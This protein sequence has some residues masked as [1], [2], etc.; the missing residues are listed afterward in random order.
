MVIVGAGLTTESPFPHRDRPAPAWSARARGAIR[1]CVKTFDRGRLA[2][3]TTSP[4]D[5]EA[6]DWLL[7]VELCP[8]L[9]LRSCLSD[10]IGNGHR[11]VPT[12]ARC[13]SRSSTWPWLALV[14][15]APPSPRCRDGI[16]GKPCRSHSSCVI[17]ARLRWR[18]RFVHHAL[19]DGCR[20]ASRRVD[21]RGAQ[22]TPA[23]EAAPN[24]ATHTCG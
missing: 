5:N 9:P 3:A 7:R 11:P 4:R 10:S 18:S 6:S 17:A 1:A 22:H 23:T 20:D 12:Q 21:A 24:T 13:T 16:D 14:T 19:L 2:L 15:L 8:F